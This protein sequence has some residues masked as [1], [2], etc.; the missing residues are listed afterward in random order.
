MTFKLL[1]Q[2]HILWS[3]LM[4]FAFGSVNAQQTA[5]I[6]GVLK[7][8][9]GQPL[10]LV[11]IVAK[12]NQDLLTTSNEK[13]FF[14]LKVPANQM[15]TIVFTSLNVKPFEKKMELK[16]NEVRE[17][18]FV[19]ES[20]ENI[21]KEVDIKDRTT[22]EQ[23]SL[24]EVKVDNQLLPDASG[25]GI[26]TFLA[27]QTLGFSKTNEL[28][29][30]Y[31]VRGGNFDENLVYVNDFEVYRPFLI[32]SGQQEGLTFP[33]P[34][35]V[36]NIKFSSG[37]F[38]SR[39]GD[40]LSSVLD[41]TYKRPK[42]WGG[43]FS[44]SLL[45]FT[46][47]LEGCDKSK[48]FT[49]LVG[50]RQKLSQYIVRSLET[51]GQYSPSFIDVQ[52]FATYL[53]NEKW[54]VELISN[55]ANNRFF[56]APDS[57]TTK[58][59]SVQDVKQLEMAFEGSEND[60]YSSFMNGLALNFFPKENIK[61]KLLASVYNN[62]EKETF[63]IISDYRIGD[64][65]TDQSKSNYGEVSSFRG[66]G[67]IQNHARNFLN[68]GI[69]QVAHRGTWIT[70]KHSVAWG[71]D[72]KHER[73]NDK[74]NEWDRLD[75]AGYSLHYFDDQKSFYGDSMAPSANPTISMDNVLK[76]TFTLNSNRITAYIQ[77]TWRLGKE[78][79]VTFNYGLRLHYWD[80]N[81]EPV[82]TP[83]VQFSFRPKTKKNAD[84]IFTLSGGM[85]YQPPFYREMRAMDGVVNLNLKAQKSVHIVAGA[86]YAFKAWKR[87]FLFATEVYYKYLWDIVPYEFD[88]VLIR[89]NGLNNAKGFSTGLDMRLNGQLAEGLESWISMS[90]MGTFNDIEGDKKMVF[91]DSLG[92]TIKYVNS[93]NSDQVRDTLFQDIGYQPRPTDQRVTFNLY[94]QD[95]IPKFP[96]IRFN[97]NLVF[98]SGLPFK[99]PGADAYTDKN[100]MPFYRR[101][102]AGFSGQLWNPKW[103]KTKTKLS[104][105]FKSVWISIDVLNI[106]GISNT[107]SY[108]WV[109]D[110]YNN[111][112]AV[113]NYLT[114]RRINA[115][116]VFNF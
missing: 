92:N 20:K 46:G 8:A 99:S 105:G 22:R 87:P 27:A 86:S 104:E 59:G 39:Y 95:Y 21:L 23:G 77:D 108:T 115:K 75:S 61:L 85:Y 19:L 58:F 65:E 83:R 15:W 33:N 24:S 88:N 9:A 69:Y 12:E 4:L 34:N 2:K 25:G 102:D 17:L 44:A 79:R 49:F 91:V 98:G 74:I 67:G 71:V 110:F 42:A 11:N 3:V 66:Y 38:Q 76:G 47:H 113:P 13:G 6:K 62:S 111:Q 68:T 63:D 18:N 50:F 56:F 55:Y 31:S 78:E 10:E 64:V 35:L 41:V 114:N 94:F 60:R 52:L 28:S 51:K 70:G 72:Y 80:V 116:V 93:T 82:I 90:V 30:N 96:F 103:A 84:V 106:F 32:R 36:S 40:K 29:S 107:V 37:G 53:I 26:E 101:V 54:N 89:Y 100:R 45:G 14:E 81:K 7:N 112:Y 16:P 43:S 109:K 48:R 97:L 73:L 1:F 5:T 57:R